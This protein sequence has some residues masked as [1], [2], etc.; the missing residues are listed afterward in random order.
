MNINTSR[1]TQAPRCLH[2]QSLLEIE[3]MVT[4]CLNITITNKERVRKSIR[5]QI[6]KNLFVFNV[7]PSIQEAKVYIKDYTA[8]KRDRLILT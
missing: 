2:L 8:A 5:N 4:K 1:A 3:L 6:I 7:T